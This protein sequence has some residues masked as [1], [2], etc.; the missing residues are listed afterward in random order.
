MKRLIYLFPILF[1]LVFS[2]E[3][4]PDKGEYGN[5]LLKFYGD[6]KEDIGYSIAETADG[7]IICGKLTVLERDINL[8]GD[9][10]IKSEN[11]NFGLIKTDKSGT[12]QWAYNS[13][14]QWLDEGRKVL[15]LDDG[16]FVCIGTV[17]K[18]AA[19]T[20]DSDILVAKVSS[21]GDLIWEKT[22]GNLLNQVGYDIIHDEASGGFLVVGSDNG[23]QNGNESGNRDMYILSID[24]SGNVVE[25]YKPGKSTDEVAKKVL[26]FNGIFYVIGITDELPRGYVGP[27]NYNIAIIPAEF[28][29]FTGKDYEVYGMGGDDEV[30]DVVSLG[31]EFAIVGTTTSGVDSKEGLFVKFGPGVLPESDSVDFSSFDLLASSNV[32]EINS[33]TLVPG[34]GLMAAGT[35]GGTDQSGDMLFLFLDN[36]GNNISYPKTYITGGTGLQTVYD[37]IIDSEGKVVAVG[38]NSYENNSLITLIKFDPWE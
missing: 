13:G 10:V 30:S 29:N 24:A 6:A 38:I 7:Y 1:L 9:T 37:A 8:T 26:L 28:G 22:Y 17:T 11:A 12:Q 18:G 5:P 4:P 15:V 23:F 3:K 19:G 20:T 16:S 14:D 2:C 21:A 25:E 35:T 34:V 31:N 33:I 32:V 36:D 27:I